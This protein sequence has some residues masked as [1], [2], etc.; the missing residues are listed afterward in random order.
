MCPT[1]TGRAFS[2]TPDEKAFRDGWHDGGRA[3]TVEVEVREDSVTKD[4]GVSLPVAAPFGTM[5]AR[6]TSAEARARRVLRTR[7]VTPGRD[8]CSPYADEEDEGSAHGTL[9]E[10]N[11]CDL[12]RRDA[13]LVRGSRKRTWSS[14]V[15]SK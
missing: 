14:S 3:V 15:S 5:D 13:R 4:A 9:K 6:S 7:F 12:G 11:D 10:L 1:L 8:G 2:S